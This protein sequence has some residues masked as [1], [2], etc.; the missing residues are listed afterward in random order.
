MNKQISICDTLP[1]DLLN[2]KKRFDTWPTE[3][4][5]YLRTYLDTAW[6]TIYAYH[7][8][9][10]SGNAVVAA[11]TQRVDT[12]IQALY[13][14]AIEEHGEPTGFAVIAQGGYGRGALNPHSDID[15]LFLFNKKVHEGDPITRAILH[16]LWDLRFD[17]G[18]S[19]RTLSDCITAA[20]DDAD[21]MTAMLETRHLVGDPTLKPQLQDALAR[22]FYG[23]RASGF[24]NKKTQER[25]QR[26]S[27]F[28]FSTQLLEPNI[29]ESPGGLRDIHT[30]GWFLMARRGIRAPEG[31]QESHIL[32]RRNYEIYVKAFDFMLRTRSELHF[33]TGKPFDVLEHDLQLVIAKNLGYQD[34]D[35][36]L[37]VEHFMRDYYTHARAIKHLSDLI[38][39]R[40]KGQSS[41]GRAVGLLTRRQ[42]DDGSV[43]HHTH[44]ALPQKRRHFFD[45]TPH[46][47]LSLFLNSQRF[48]VPLNE[49]AKQGIKD[50]LHLIDDTFRSSER[51]SRTFLD[52]FRTPVGIGTTLRTMHELD[53]LGTY[54]PEFGSL[55]CLVQYNRYHIYTADEHT[56][57][58]V[59][60]LDYLAR[61]PSL[62]HDLQHLKRVYNE[63]PRKELLY[64]ALL[65]HDVGK[66]VRDKDHS[67][68]GAEM[69][70]DFLKRLQLPDDQIET[71]VFLVRHHLAM[72]AIAQ[73]R[74]L[75]DHR[76]IAEFA[77]TFSHPD[78]LRMLY[79]LTYADLSAV[80]QTA[81]TAWKG[82]LLRELY[83][84]TFYLLT[85][86]TQPDREHP[87]L[88]DIQK[89]L[90]ALESRIPH[91]T[92]VE[93]LNNMPPRYP[94]QNSPEEIAQHL[95]LIDA[96]GSSL[97]AVSVQPGELFLEITICTHDQ[98]FRLSEI[99]GVLATHDINIF[100][101]H[102]YTRNDGTVIDIFQVT[103]DAENNATLREKIQQTLTDVFQQKERV[104]DLFANYSQRWSLKRQ[105]T[106]PIS[107]KITF[108]NNVSM[109]STVIDITAQDAIGLL[110]RITRTLSDL[111]F[112]IYTA[113]IGTQ[114]DRAVDAFYV[115][116][117]GDKITDPALL[118]HIASELTHAIENP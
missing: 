81:W 93:H 88:Q 1:R 32:T 62:P 2:E 109:R 94:E 37:G 53:I 89:I 54:V 82:H 23:R 22:R 21:S 77:S 110:Y 26:H 52:L 95:Q 64:L 17:V 76:M 24:I 70:R 117:N 31:L 6:E 41:T 36:E 27:K 73:R 45:N 99:C 69:T 80:T 68:V 13:A 103:S 84:N 79:V 90:T 15:L 106:V 85:Q 20:Q 56:L 115:R 10:A 91:Q 105:P 16:T 100:S 67:I 29:K 92:L 113:R 7:Q 47:L 102:A 46:R 34:R 97:V 11:L 66:S 112:D 40:L 63:I 42:L 50:H 3:R 25:I 72:S 33:H 65:M 60:R 9:G 14:E 104:S 114:A 86:R 4:L 108:D 18:Y 19:T 44:I 116:K 75:S 49:A 35:N 59:E 39:E 51:I 61:S 101:A 87:E 78:T 38:C 12:L 74:D 5:S 8:S 107:P 98:P 57:V 28:K 96:M 48:G 118:E 58:A 83:E 111:G 71:V 30:A 55:T 43:L